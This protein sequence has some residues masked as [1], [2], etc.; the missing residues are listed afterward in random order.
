MSRQSQLAY[1]EPPWWYYPARQSLAAL[2]V[3]DGQLDRAEQLFRE[4]LVESPN[5]ALAYYGLEQT[6]RGMGDR[7]LARH[8]RV[9]FG[10]AWLGG[11]ARPDLTDL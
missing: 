9:Q 4:S 8:A 6:Y 10:R 3:R 1:M 5:N 11:R 2:L 7:M